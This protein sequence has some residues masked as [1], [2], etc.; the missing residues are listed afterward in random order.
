MLAVADL[1]LNGIA[2][3]MLPRLKY[4]DVGLR[5]EAAFVRHSADSDAGDVFV[6]LQRRPALIVLGP[7]LVGDEYRYLVTHAK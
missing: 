6:R 1:G 7:D 5:F 4:G 3:K 2:P